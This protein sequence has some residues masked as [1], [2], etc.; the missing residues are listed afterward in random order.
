M[1]KPTTP[2]P[3]E[4]KWPV[5]GNTITTAQGMVYTIGQPLNQ[6]GYALVFE[7]MDLFGNAVALKVYKPAGRPFE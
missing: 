2:A 1:T 3:I 7:G 4:G 6:G 5:P